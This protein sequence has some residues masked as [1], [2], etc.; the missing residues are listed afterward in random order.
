MGHGVIGGNKN[1]IADSEAV[2]GNHFSLI[3]RTMDKLADRP[4]GAP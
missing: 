3:A 4:A 2:R 1:A